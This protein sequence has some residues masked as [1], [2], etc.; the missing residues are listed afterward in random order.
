MAKITA[1]REARAAPLDDIYLTALDVYGAELTKAG[2]IK[3]ASQIRVLREST[4]QSSKSA[5]PPVTSP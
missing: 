4:W 3:E 5:P 2:R 1:A